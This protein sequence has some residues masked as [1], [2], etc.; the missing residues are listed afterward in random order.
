MKSCSPDTG[1]SLSTVYTVIVTFNGMNWLPKCLNSLI[2]NQV[3][4]II[5]VDNHS[6]DGTVDWLRQNWPGI[7]L[8]PL[9]EN[10][11]F[12]RANNIGIQDALDNGA[13]WILLANQDIIFQPKSIQ[14]LLHAISADPELGIVSAFQLN[15]DGTGID[16]AFR[17]YLPRTFYDDLYFNRPRKAIYST[18]FVP[19][20]C[21]LI[22]REVFHD[23]GGFDPLFFLYG[24]DDELCTRVLK[25]GWKLGIVPNAVVWHWHGLLQRKRSFLW[26]INWEYSRSIIALKASRRSIVLAYLALI[27]RTFFISFSLK[28]DLTRWLSKVVGIAKAGLRLSTIARHRRSIPYEFITLPD[29]HRSSVQKVFNRQA[30]RDKCH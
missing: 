20:A 21:V 13:E 9:N 11:G 26:Y 2:E 1:I 28:E 10:L 27:W 12:G 4:N 30:S 3:T 16:D 8:H 5:V 17:N 19:G 15:G 14:A 6:T 25:R 23:V 22:R 29:D 7:R 24:E 18:H